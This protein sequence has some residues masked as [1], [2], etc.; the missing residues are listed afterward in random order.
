[1]HKFFNASRISGDISSQEREVISPRASNV[2]KREGQLY[3]SREIA[4]GSKSHLK[5]SGDMILN[6]TTSQQGTGKGKMIY[7]G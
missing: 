5:D 3:D 4:G 6:K 2:E 1:V 7:V